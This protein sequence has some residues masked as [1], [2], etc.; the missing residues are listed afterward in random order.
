MKPA[1]VN[2]L[3]NTWVKGILEETVVWKSFS[4]RF[5]KKSHSPNIP[6]L[7]HPTGQT[8]DIPNIPHPKHSTF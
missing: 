4:K 1:I 7:E 8:S 3:C 2:T 6:H 5:C